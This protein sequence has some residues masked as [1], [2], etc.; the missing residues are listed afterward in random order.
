M[1]L[2]ATGSNL[3]IH[4]EPAGQ[5]FVTN[6]IGDPKKAIDELGFKYQVELEEGLKELIAWRDSHIQLVSDRRKQAELQPA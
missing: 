6:R 4:Y 1:I 3:S 2:S 5:T